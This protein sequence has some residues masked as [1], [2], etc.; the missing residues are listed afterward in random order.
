MPI[1]IV[2]GTKAGILG[3]LVGGAGRAGTIGNTFLSESFH[4][5]ARVEHRVEWCD[6][7]HRRR[8]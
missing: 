1:W 3:S 7:R 4:D 2:G 8:Q 5:N 6:F